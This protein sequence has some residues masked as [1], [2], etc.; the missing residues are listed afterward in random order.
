VN[1]SFLATSRQR[2]A[3][4]E[5]LSGRF[6]QLEPLATR[7]EALGIFRA[8]QNG[9]TFLRK[10]LCTSVDM[11]RSLKES[12]QQPFPKTL[13]SDFHWFAVRCRRGMETLVDLKL[14]T[15]L[16]ETLLPLAKP[17]SRQ[18]RR[19]WPHFPRPFFA[20]YLFANFCAA[21]SLNAV[22]LTRGVLR[23]VSKKGAPVPLHETIITSLRQRVGP[24]GFIE[25]AESSTTHRKGLQPASDPT[26]TWA[27]VFEP[28]LSDECRV[29]LLIRILEESREI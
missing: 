2:H 4:D 20:G 7:Y 6:L 23:V 13:V 26:A 5:I 11:I 10:S 16:I 28:Q 18:P 15:M 12:T 22:A 29:Q 19:I 21:T 27:S 8:F 3:W 9:E 1:P 24:D 25:L 17:S 14:R